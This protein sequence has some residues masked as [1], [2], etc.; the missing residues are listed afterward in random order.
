MFD[1]SDYDYT[2]PPE[3]IAQTAT[4][5]PSSCKLLIYH[6]K[7]Q[8]IT[9]AVF[10]DLSI[11]IKPST[12]IFFND[13]KV[14]KARLVFQGLEIFYLNA[15]DT[16]RFHALVRPWR[17]F[18][19]GKT[20]HFHD[21]VSFHVDALT[22][23]WRQLTCSHPIAS[24]L[25]KYGQMPLP[26]YITYDTSKE[27]DYQSIFA[28]KQGSVAAPTASLHFTSELID[29]LHAQGVQTM[30]TTLHV[31]LGTFKQVNTSN[32]KNYDIHAESIEIDANIFS[33]IATQKI[34]H[35]PILAVGTTVTR[36][37]ESLPYL[38]KRLQDCDMQTF[39]ILSSKLS[40]KT[41]D[42]RN[43]LTQDISLADAHQT[44][45][46]IQYHPQT[47]QICFSSKLFLYPGKTFF[48]ID[49]LITNFHL[50]KSSLLMLVAW[51]IGYEQMKKVYQHAIDKK[52]RFYSFGDA[53]WIQG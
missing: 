43:Q 1:L 35:H 48:I 12:L 46:D 53:M 45:F 3:L 42:F 15:L 28:S 44:I 5:P 7:T 22:T 37:L 23:E 2:L 51:F 4:H 41:Q 20:L 40:P 18:K 17:K 34:A 33:R 29:Q 11:Y 47:H 24:V 16:Y 36:S 32:I 9:D 31:W 8:S 10:S 50:P 52:Y 30:H 19:V 21:N 14:I 6:K 13:T 49:E 25:E 38:W 26:P 27:K 39:S